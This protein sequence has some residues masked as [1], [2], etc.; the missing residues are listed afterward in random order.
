MITPH[1]A[2]LLL[3]HLDID[4]TLIC[5]LGNASQPLALSTCFKG[6]ITEHQSQYVCL[7]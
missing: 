2:F 1:S 7:T 6:N 4:N 5:F 3:S